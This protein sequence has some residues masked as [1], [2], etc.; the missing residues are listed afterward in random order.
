MRCLRTLREVYAADSSCSVCRRFVRC[1]RS[2]RE[3]SA[4]AS[5]ITVS[6]RFAARI[7]G[8]PI[9]EFRGKFKLLVSCTVYVVHTVI[10][11]F[12]YPLQLN[13]LLRLG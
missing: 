10:P 11:V 13:S 12:H 8:L 5:R 6:L 9:R 4:D 3:M 2:R 7:R 1:A